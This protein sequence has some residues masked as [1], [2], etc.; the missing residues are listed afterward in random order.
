MRKATL[1]IALAV[2]LAPI[3]GF[4]AVRWFT[5]HRQIGLQ[6]MSPQVGGAAA[7]PVR[8]P[9][10]LAAVLPSVSVPAFIGNPK[11][12]RSAGRPRTMRFRSVTEG[13]S[14]GKSH[15]RKASGPAAAAGPRRGDST[16]RARPAASKKLKA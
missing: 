16:A 7:T 6:A 15:K 5:G 1:A 13:A 3:T 11:D 14:S 2:L 8:T 10:E 12:V 4:T 9:A